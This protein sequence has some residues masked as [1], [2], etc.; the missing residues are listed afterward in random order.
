MPDFAFDGSELGRLAR[1][2][3][4]PG[5]PTTPGTEGSHRARR[6]GQGTDFLDYRSYVPGDDIRRIDWVVYARLRQPFIRVLEHEETLFVHFLVDLSQSMAAGHS[7]SKAGLACQ[8]TAG[9]AYVALTT[10]D[11]VGVA[12]FAD[13]LSSGLRDLHGRGAMRRLIEYLKNAPT[14]GGSNMPAVAQTFCRRAKRRGLV[15]VLS[16]FLG[17]GSVDDVVKTLLAHRFRVLLVQILD[18][19]DWGEGLTGS[20]R[21]MDSESRLSID[22][23]ASPQ[24]VAEYRKRV[25]DY[26]SRLKAFCTRRGQNYLLAN[27][28]DNYLE[29]L[30][31]GL[32]QKGLLR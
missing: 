11:Y 1:L 20:I 26:A 27:T 23:V 30:A 16:D 25:R 7:T 6:T 8:I 17:T 3:Y 21:L 32:R 9:L 10:G 4:S 14:G 12:S 29:L 28:Q 5:I 18:A 19:I 2:T 31:R 22:I 13:D 15:V 24:R